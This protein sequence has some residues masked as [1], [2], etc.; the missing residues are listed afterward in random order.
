MPKGNPIGSKSSVVKRRRRKKH[1]G[2]Q[3][4]TKWKKKEAKKRPPKDV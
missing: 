1:S 2:F 4:I 3:G